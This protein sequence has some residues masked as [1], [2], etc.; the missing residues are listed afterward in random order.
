MFSR[1]IT[2]IFPYTDVDII[3]PRNEAVDEHV[4]MRITELYLKIADNLTTLL[5]KNYVKN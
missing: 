5:P 1:Y 4:V 2:N 3:K